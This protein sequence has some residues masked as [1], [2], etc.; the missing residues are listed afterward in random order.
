MIIQLHNSQTWPGEINEFINQHEL[1]IRS[2]V[3]SSQKSEYCL[4]QDKLYI[5]SEDTLEESKIRGSEFQVFS[6]E[7]R[8]L[9][10]LH[11]LE[12]VHCT[13]LL[14]HEIEDIKHNGLRI[15]TTDLVRE[16]INAAFEHKY[17]SAPER[18]FLL[19]DYQRKLSVRDF[20]TRQNQLWFVTPKHLGSESCF[21]KRSFTSW[22]GESVYNEHD[23]M[24]TPIANK[25]KAI[26]IPCIVKANVL[27]A[28]L[29][30][31]SIENAM[32]YA[33]K[34]V[35]DLGSFPEFDNTCGDIEGFVINDIS[36]KFV[37]EIIDLNNPKFSK[38]YNQELLAELVSDLSIKQ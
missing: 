14:P 18:D 36:A 3:E 16:R 31:G 5:P 22:G 12:M 23:H 2:F 38:L 17:L 29:H 4:D 34:I 26:G 11:R 30:R 21:V 6:R 20:I 25:L 32:I 8:R 28:D 7:L 1:L 37:D 15:L 33:S 35:V 19:E 10:N 24:K 9:L 27:I 13:K